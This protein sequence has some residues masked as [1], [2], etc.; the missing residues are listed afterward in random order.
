MEEVFD[1]GKW[2]FEHRATDIICW[3]VSDEERIPRLNVKPLAWELAEQLIE[4][5]QFFTRKERQNEW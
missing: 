3:F 5:K 4:M 1:V 2:E